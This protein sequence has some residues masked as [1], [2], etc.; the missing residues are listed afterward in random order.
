[1]YTLPSRRGNFIAEG[2]ANANARQNPGTLHR[3]SD[4]GQ[5]IGAAGGRR[6]KFR[7][8]SIVE[9]VGRE[10]AAKGGMKLATKRGPSRI[11]AG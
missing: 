2:L 4:K 7:F 11:A 3:Q 8:G 6:R 10:R 1:M 9:G 5:P